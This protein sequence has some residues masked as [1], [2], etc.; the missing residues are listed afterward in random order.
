MILL[1]IS[2]W[3][4]IVVRSCNRNKGS[5]QDLKAECISGFLPFSR[6]RRS[7]KLGHNLCVLFF[8]SKNSLLCAHTCMQTRMSNQAAARS[9]NPLLRH[10]GIGG[11]MRDRRYCMGSCDGLSH[12][13]GYGKLLW[14]LWVV[15]YKRPAHTLSTITLSSSLTQRLCILPLYLL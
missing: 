5:F 2:R 15:V 11:L 10:K 4:G 14:N 3:M 7:H 8:I 13:G 12:V 9:T 1:F 6:I